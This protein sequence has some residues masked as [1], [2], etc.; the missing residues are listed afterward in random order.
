[1]RTAIIGGVNGGV[2]SAIPI[3]NLLRCCFC[4]PNMAGAA[5]GI[6][7][8][9]KEHPGENLSDGDAAISGTISGGIAGAIAGVVG[10]IIN[11][12]LGSLLVG[13]YR[14]MPADVARTLAQ[15]SAG[16]AAG[17]IVAPIMYAPFGAL[18]GFLSM[19]L[20]FKERRKSQR[21]YGSVRAHGDP[22]PVDP[23]IPQHPLAGAGR[24]LRTLVVLHGPNGAGKSNLLLAAQL[25]LRAAARPG[26][27]P[28]GRDQ[29]RVL[30][31]A[32]A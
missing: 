29:A 1:M 7:M 31:P 28:I 23:G 2:D 26:C 11:L 22:A 21:V 5:I 20:F 18:G 14:N 17:I 3:V 27:L 12:A 30:S 6:S 10:F 25:L 15:V 13:F 8:Y 32:Q 19:Q 16:G 4:L 24:G 9:L